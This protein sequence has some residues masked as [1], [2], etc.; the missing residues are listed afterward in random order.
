MNRLLTRSVDLNPNAKKVGEEIER[1]EEREKKGV[2]LRNLGT[3]R[4]GNRSNTFVPP[5][6]S[7]RV[8]QRTVSRTKDQSRR[9]VKLKKL[10]I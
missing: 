8:S 1:R 10:K 9:G 2:V 5:K 4:R 6:T 3:T 7:S